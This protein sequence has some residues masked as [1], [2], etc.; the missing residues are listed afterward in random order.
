MELNKLNK[1]KPTASKRVGRGESSGKGKTSGKGYKGQ[2]SR[3]GGKVRLGFEGGQ[4]PLIKRLPFRRGVGNN[5]AKK[6]LTITLD[7]LSVFSSGDTVEPKTLLEKGLLKKAARPDLIRVVAK[8]EI[9]KPL[10]IK[11]SYTKSAKL[12][13]EKAKG[14]IVDIMGNKEEKSDA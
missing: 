5:L 10:T 3:G 8:G 14:K 2:K 1:I 7:Q 13:I 11:V 12:A 9:S 6:T 4:L